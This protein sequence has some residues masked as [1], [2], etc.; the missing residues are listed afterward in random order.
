MSM[1]NKVC[2]I[3]G[4]TSGIGQENVLALVCTV[5]NY[6]WCAATLKRAKPNGLNVAANIPRSNLYSCH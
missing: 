2:L 1:L 3:T 5:Q 6:L 4:A